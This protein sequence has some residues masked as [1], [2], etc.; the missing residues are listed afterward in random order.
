[1]IENTPG[2]TPIA[3][4]PTGSGSLMEFSPICAQ[5]TLVRSSPPLIIPLSSNTEKLPQPSM[6][7]DV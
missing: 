1:C 5:S 2:I 6:A 4:Q 3:A 7:V